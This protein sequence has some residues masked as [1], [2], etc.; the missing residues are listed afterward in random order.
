MGTH[1]GITSRKRYLTLLYTTSLYKGSCFQ[2]HGPLYTFLIPS[3]LIRAS[4]NAM[5]SCTLS[6]DKV[7]Y[8]T[9][10]LYNNSV[11]F[12]IVTR[13]AVESILNNPPRDLR[14]IKIKEL[15]TINA[16]LKVPVIVE[17]VQ[18][19]MRIANEYDRIKTEN[20]SKPV[21]KAHEFITADTHSHGKLCYNI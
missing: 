13:R 11:S 2:R 17:T 6:Q 10:E 20:V 14:T 12:R 18:E 8:I 16:G 19:V 4:N 9:A 1:V 3:T 7:V 21:R 15:E 5:K